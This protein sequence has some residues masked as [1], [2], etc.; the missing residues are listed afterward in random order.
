[1]RVLEAHNRPTIVVWYQ[2]GGPVRS[3]RTTHTRNTITF[4]AQYIAIP[5]VVPGS[6]PIDQ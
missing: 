2:L 6:S 4:G 1:M 5:A 3:V